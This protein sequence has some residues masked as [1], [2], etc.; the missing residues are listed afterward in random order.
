MPDKWFQNWFNSPYYH[1]LYKN[2]NDEEAKYFI[3][4]ICR[5]IAP[6]QD[7]RM[8]DIACGRGR[9]AIYLNKLGYDVTGIDLATANISFARQFENERLHFFTHDMRDLMYIN[10]FDVAWNIFTSFG[11]FDTERDHIK[12]LKAFRKGLKAGGLLVLDY[13]NRDKIVQQLK[14]HE[15]KTIGGMSF[16][17]HKF[18]E[19]NKVIKRIEFSS[20]THNFNYQEEVNLFSL[21]DFKRMFDASGFE[22]VQ[23]FG[24]YHLDEFSSA[25]SDR[26]IFICKVL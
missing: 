20:D 1:I 2:H 7:A 17:I 5:H 10:Y 3:N 19:N 12:A 21:S 23:I 4:N 24:N 16:D 15:M 18:I 11:Y 9:H 14:P 6:N 26:L 13:F 8:L 22:I 25:N